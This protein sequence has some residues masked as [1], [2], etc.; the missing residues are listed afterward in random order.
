M[1]LPVYHCDTILICPEPWKEVG[2]GARSVRV[3]WLE[4]STRRAIFN[5]VHQSAGLQPK[6]YPLPLPLSHGANVPRCDVCPFEKGCSVWVEIG[7]WVSRN[8]PFLPW[9]RSQNWSWEMLSTPTNSSRVTDWLPSIHKHRISIN[10]C[11][12]GRKESYHRM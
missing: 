9:D 5:S 3:T 12:F 8:R 2:S 1:G 11:S 6:V 10:I 4:P 7:I